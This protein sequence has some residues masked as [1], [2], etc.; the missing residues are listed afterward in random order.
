MHQNDY[1]YPSERPIIP[2]NLPSNVFLW[3]ETDYEVA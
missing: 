3:A 1:L 2:S